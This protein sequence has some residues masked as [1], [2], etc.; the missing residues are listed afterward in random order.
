MGAF[1]FSI[2][3]I[4]IFASYLLIIIPFLNTYSFQQPDSLSY[5]AEKGKYDDVRRLATFQLSSNKGASQRS[6][7]YLSLS[8]QAG[9]SKTALVKTDS[10]LTLAIFK[11]HTVWKER[12]K[13]LRISYLRKNGDYHSAIEQGK[14][15]NIDDSLSGF[16]VSRAISISFRK[17]NQYDSALTWAIALEKLALASNSRIDLHRALQNKA[18]LYDALNQLDKTLTIEK[19]LLAIADELEN[20]DLQIL[21][22]CNLGSSYTNLGIFD[23]ARVYYEQALFLAN[24]NSN[25][26]RTPLILYNIGSLEH[27]RKD[28]KAAV[29]AL[30]ECL[31]IAQQTSQ[32]S[33]ISLTHYL[34]AECYDKL[35]YQLNTH[36]HLQLGKMTAQKHGFLQDRLYLMELEFDIYQRR[37]EHN[38]AIVTLQNI[39]SLEDSILNDEKVKSI[40]ELETRYETEKKNKEIELLTSE[41]AIQNLTI[42]QQQ[43]LITLAVG[44][45]VVLMI[46]TFLYVRQR[47][48]KKDNQVLDIENKLLR[49]QMNPHFLF[50]ALSAIQQFVHNKKDPV[51][52]GDY[53]GKFARLTRM[54]LDHSQEEH[55]SLEQEVTFIKYYIDIQKIRFN[56]SF[57]STIEVDDRLRTEDVL[58]PPMITQPFVENAIE[59]GIRQTETGGEVKIK[60]TIKDTK[61]LEIVIED[62]GVGRKVTMNK[63]G[64]SHQSRATKITHERLNMLTSRHRQ[65]SSLT[66]DDL[67]GVKGEAIGTKVILNL[68]LIKEEA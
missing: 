21:D 15:L 13:A 52:T 10:I 37:G 27:E 68:P 18:N 45:F 53:I 6:L 41:S 28:Y 20:S 60:F 36:K 2:R 49:T 16:T 17:L 23:T 25:S 51:E 12:L 57:N 48:L 7:Y 55:I 61:Q 11:K 40:Q 63:E 26:N 56:E 30:L 34:L 58:I 35:G 3:H 39:R 62:N 47:N 4:C 46:F 29:D 59:H 22:R 19:Q 65:K 8:Y 44:I 24:E 42:Q 31:P 67:V 66:I 5:F 9:D 50:N 33:I 43:I 54:I 32:P 1:A 38:E 64:K 14:E